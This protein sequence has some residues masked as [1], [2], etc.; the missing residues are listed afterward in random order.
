MISIISTPDS[1]KR[2]IAI[3]NAENHV[4]GSPIRSKDVASVK[5]ETE[6]FLSEVMKLRE[7]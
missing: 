4:L 3:P 6:S 5:K 2:A 1:L 7:L